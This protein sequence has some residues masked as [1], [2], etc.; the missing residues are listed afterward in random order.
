[1]E[2]QE[3]VAVSII[4]HSRFFNVTILVPAELDLELIEA[5]RI[6]SPFSER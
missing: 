5:T 3:D 4:E 6:A 2:G 1:M